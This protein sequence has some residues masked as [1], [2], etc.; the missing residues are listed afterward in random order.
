MRALYVNHLS[1]L[2]ERCAA[3]TR[4]KIRTANKKASKELHIFAAVPYGYKKA[5]G[6]KELSQIAIQLET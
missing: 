3:Q 2:N 4:K 5:D 6:S 1:D